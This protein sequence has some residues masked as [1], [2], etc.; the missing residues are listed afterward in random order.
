MPPSRNF[1]F[2]N[3]KANK[4]LIRLLKVYRKAANPLAK[5]LTQ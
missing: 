1:T 2:A 3:K 5:K 4:Q